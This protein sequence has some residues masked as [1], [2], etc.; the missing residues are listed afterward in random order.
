MTRLA[1]PLLLLAGVCAGVSVG[2]SESAHHVRRRQAAPRGAD[3]SK[4]CLRCICAAR[5]C[6]WQAGCQGGACGGYRITEPYFNHSNVTRDVPLYRERTFETCTVDPQC[7]ITVVRLYMR[8]LATDCD[9]SGD[10]DCDDMMLTHFYGIEGCIGVRD[11]A[12]FTNDWA[13]YRDCMK[14]S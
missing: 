13:R 11:I 8:T 9:Q 4:T 3:I 6:D 5:L 12:E 2:V 1:P 14:A 10:I 7:A